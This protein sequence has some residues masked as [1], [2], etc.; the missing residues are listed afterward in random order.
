ME[1]EGPLEGPGLEDGTRMGDV[2]GLLGS[3]KLETWGHPGAWLL[4][5]QTQSG[6]KSVV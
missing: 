5:P 3:G 1:S 6:I 2:Q 4:G